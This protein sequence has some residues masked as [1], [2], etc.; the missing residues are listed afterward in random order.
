VILAG[1]A[2]AVVG[3][4]VSIIMRAAGYGQVERVRPQT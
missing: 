4:I 3:V 2:V 1:A